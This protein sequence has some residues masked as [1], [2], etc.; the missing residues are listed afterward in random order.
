MPRKTFIAGNWKM[1]KTVDES[2]V[3][4]KDVVAQVGDVSDVEVA[5]CVPYTSLTEVARVIDGTSVKLGAQDVYWE[6]SGAFTGKVSCEMLRSAGVEY[7]IVGHSEQRSYFGE[8]DEA[9]NKKVHAVIGAGLHPIVCVGETLQERE[10]AVT[11]AVVAR[12]VKAAY[13][14]VSA[15]DAKKTTIAYEPVWAIGTGKTATPE[16]AQE[17]HGTIRS[18]LADMYDQDT[19]DSI[20]IQYGGSMKPANAK[21]LLEKPDIDGGLIGGAALNADTFRGVVLPE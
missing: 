15:A 19:A 4:A 21:G 10:D 17:V 3:L 6:E 13:D 16:M 5:I 12:Q 7:V 1:N 9:V 14:N 11:D 18:L 8:T 20:V 2:V